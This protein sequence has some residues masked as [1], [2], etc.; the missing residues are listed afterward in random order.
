MND[1]IGKRDDVYHLKIFDYA[2]EEV[3][4]R[5]YQIVVPNLPLSDIDEANCRAL[6]SSFYNYIF[7]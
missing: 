6:A 7:D 4:P 5:V 3:Y 1:V 2:H